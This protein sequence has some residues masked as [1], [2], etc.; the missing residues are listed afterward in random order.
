MT[1]Y[2]TLVDFTKDIYGRLL[3][4]GLNT[5]AGFTMTT[6]PMCMD[7]FVFF[8]VDDLPA[9]H[10]A[11]HFTH[12]YDV[13]L[14]DGAR[15]VNRTPVANL[16][17]YHADCVLLSNHRTMNSFYMNDCTPAKR[18]DIVRRC[19]FGFNYVPRA[20][21]FLAL[22]AMVVGKTPGY[23]KFMHAHDRYE[24]PLRMLAVTGRGFALE[25]LAPH[26][27]L[28]MCVRMVA[29]VMSP[30]VIEHLNISERQDEP[31]L[32]L[33]AVL[34]NGRLIDE[35][36]PAERSMEVRAAA[37]AQNGMCLAD[38]ERTAL[39]NLP[40]VASLRRV[41]ADGSAIR[42]EPPHMRDMLVVQLA[43]VLNDG[44]AI[45][46]LTPAQRQP[47]ALRLAAMAFAPRAVVHLQ[48]HE[49]QELALRMTV[50]GRNGHC[51]A[52]LTPEERAHPWVRW[53]A[54]ARV[55]YDVPLEDL[56]P[57]EWREVQAS[58]V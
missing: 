48:P 53:M 24:L 43:A 4:P 32:A 6:N 12:V 11:K 17:R 5:G 25:H 1:Q 15:M 51:A 18:M 2:V 40:L 22:R 23:V 55:T 31:A 26:E 30:S 29:V 13:T 57:Q 10:N 38:Q 52:L 47:L 36:D 3:H 56:F 49:R 41:M 28:E 37:Y 33:A 50:V 27:R 20:A 14:P 45:Q 58:L 9:W 39:E 8:S 44:H 42:D 7:G 19:D 21:W 54:V 35:L 34:Q 16:R 46:H